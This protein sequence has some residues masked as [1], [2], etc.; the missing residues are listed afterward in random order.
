MTSGLAMEDD[1]QFQ[2]WRAIVLSL[3]LHALVVV[4][5]PRLSRIALPEIP[6]RLEIELFSMK[7]RPAVTQLAETKPEVP[8][9]QPPLSQPPPVSKAEAKPKEVLA[10]KE[11]A[12]PQDYRVSE[13]VVAPSE[14]V[15][16]APETAVSKHQAA[17]SAAPAA[18]IDHAAKEA[19]ESAAAAQPAKMTDDEE[20]AATDDE[21]WDGYGKQL[22]DMVSKSKRYPAIAIRR[23]MEGDVKIVA[24]FVKGEMVQVTLVDA[25]GHTPLDEEAIRMVKKAIAQLSVKGSLA[26]KSFKVTIPV[27]FRLDS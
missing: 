22:H 12:T 20:I 5:Y 2:V 17:E 18:S 11:P 25:S 26:K 27:S 15:A 1:G 19:R 13:P 3:L 8:V 10:T 6:E 24:Q 9:P 7:T 23:H 16:P 21:A 14:P 4:F